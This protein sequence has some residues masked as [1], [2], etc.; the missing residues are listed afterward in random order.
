MVQLFNYFG[1]IDH[2]LANAHYGLSYISFI[3]LLKAT[4]AIKI[5]LLFSKGANIQS[6]TRG[7]QVNDR[8]S[9]YYFKAYMLQ[10]VPKRGIRFR[11]H[12]RIFNY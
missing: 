3:F 12:H 4:I 1:G 2:C 9:F 5:C 6:E 10:I 11:N 7:C 8:L